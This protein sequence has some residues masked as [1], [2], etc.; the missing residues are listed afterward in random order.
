MVDSDAELSTFL[1]LHSYTG[2]W[3]KDAAATLL[4]AFVGQKSIVSQ[5]F[6]PYGSKTEHMQ[7]ST[8]LLATRRV[9][10]VVNFG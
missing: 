5:S 3:P 2:T 7:I 10:P 1:L 9:K 4:L 6:S 8:L